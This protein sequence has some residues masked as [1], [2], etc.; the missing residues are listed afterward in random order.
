LALSMCPHNSHSREE[1]RG[2]TRT[3]LTPASFALYSMK[4]RSWK[5]L[6]L[7]C[8]ARRF[9]LTVVRLRMPPRFSRAMPRPVPLAFCTACLEMMWLVLRW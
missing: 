6:Q 4:E 9:L 8:R 5:K 7:A 1:L 2:S 3:T